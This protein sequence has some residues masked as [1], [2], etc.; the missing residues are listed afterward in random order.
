MQPPL[1]RNLFIVRGGGIEP[2]IGQGEDVCEEPENPWKRKVKGRFRENT[3]GKD[4]ENSNDRFDN[5]KQPPGCDVGD[6]RVSGTGLRSFEELGGYTILKESPTTQDFSQNSGDE[7]NGIFEARAIVDGQWV[8]IYHEQ[9]D[10]SRSNRDCIY[11]SIC[12][13]PLQ[14]KKKEK[15]GPTYPT[16]TFDGLPN[17]FQVKVL[18]NPDGGAYDDT[19]NAVGERVHGSI[20]TSENDAEGIEDNGHQITVVA[21]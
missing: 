17:S 15:A 7:G 1:D 20:Y 21:R 18:E 10:R 12:W 19:R 13:L 6:G 16:S 5:G 8:L 4:E 2:S 11:V 9:T 3:P 14:K